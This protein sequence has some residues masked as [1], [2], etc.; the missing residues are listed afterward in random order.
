MCIWKL[1]C[2]CQIH[3][4]NK[5]YMSLSLCF[6]NSKLTCQS[7]C[8]ASTQWHFFLSNKGSY[9]SLKACMQKTLGLMCL[10]IFYCTY[11]KLWR[12]LIPECIIISYLY[13]RQVAKRRAAWKF[14]S[15]SLHTFVTHLDIECQMSCTAVL[16]GKWGWEGFL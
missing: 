14:G 1:H 9:Y 6:Y 3:G 8:S 12:S 2:Q 13:T 4:N 5:N 16:S 7:F 10:L 15:M 11:L